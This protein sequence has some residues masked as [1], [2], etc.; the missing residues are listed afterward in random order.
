MCLWNIYDTWFPVRLALT[1]A[2]FAAKYVAKVCSALQEPTAATP[3][4]HP[5]RAISSTPLEASNVLHNGTEQTSAQ[6]IS[7]RINT[8]S[9]GR[10]RLIGLRT[11]LL[12]AALTSSPTRSAAN[13]IY[14]PHTQTHFIRAAASARPREVIT[15]ARAHVHTLPRVDALVRFFCIGSAGSV[16]GGR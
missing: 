9:A 5:P 8:T 7:F 12:A 14:A 10:F 2:F 4:S 13:S 1:R 6:L 3:P 15:N 11:R 16:S